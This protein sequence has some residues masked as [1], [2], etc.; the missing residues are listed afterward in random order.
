MIILEKKT[1]LK[2]NEN[3]KKVQI[4]ESGTC[5]LLLVEF[6]LEILR[7]KRKSVDILPEVLSRIN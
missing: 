1:E 3:F 6:T 4:L 7:D 2:L 5:W